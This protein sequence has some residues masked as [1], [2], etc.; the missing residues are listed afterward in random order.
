MK[1][2]EKLLK[3]IILG[4][5]NERKGLVRNACQNETA[6]FVEYMKQVKSQY[7]SMPVEKLESMAKY[8]N[9]NAA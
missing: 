3:V 2:K 7:E 4:Q 5:L 1:N 9:K 8:Y 6:C